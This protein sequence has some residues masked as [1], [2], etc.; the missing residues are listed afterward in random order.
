MV[1]SVKIKPYV[2]LEKMIEWHVCKDRGYA[3]GVYV[4]SKLID[5]IENKIFPINKEHT[6]C[7]EI[8]IDIDLYKVVTIPKSFV[9]TRYSN[10]LALN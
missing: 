8:V 6:N 7:L 2:E 1:E 3:D 4:T 10:N 9:E 5:M